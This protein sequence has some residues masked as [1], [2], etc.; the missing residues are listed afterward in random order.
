MDILLAKTP[1]SFAS[2]TY[3][4]TCGNE[5]AVVDPSTPYDES[6]YSGRLKYILLTH[7]HFDHM[8]DIDSWVN[9]TDATVIVSSSEQEALSDPML[10][11]FKLYDGSDRGYF[12]ASVAVV[13]SDTL[14]LGNAFITVLATPGH[15]KGSVVYLIDGSCFVG[16]TV[17]AGGGYGRFDL[18]GG[19]AMELKESIN[20]I[21]NLP[22]DTVLYPGHGP[23]T[24]VEQYIY[25]INR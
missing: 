22:K 17:F 24:T 25:D 11:C 12:G 4:I 3:I 5:C 6:L 1:H 2:N 19:N 14:E 18:P 15:T 7:G 8:L 23:S 21:I 9:A 13:D 20:L 10:N 16:D